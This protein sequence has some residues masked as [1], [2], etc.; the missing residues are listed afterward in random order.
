MAQVYPFLASRL[1]LFRITAGLPRQQCRN[2]SL[3]LYKGP[4]H[5]CRFGHR[6]SLHPGRLY[7]LYLNRHPFHGPIREDHDLGGNPSHVLCDIHDLHSHNCDIPCDILGPLG[8]ER[9]NQGHKR[10]RLH[11][12]ID[13]NVN[14][15]GNLWLAVHQRRFYLSHRPRYR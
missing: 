7:T 1:D 13:I 11:V 14:I 3:D 5:L 6:D 12:N 4:C 8:H 15:R 10:L 2:H 9:L